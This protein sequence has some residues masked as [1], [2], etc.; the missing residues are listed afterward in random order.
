MLTQLSPTADLIPL[1]Q[2]KS[3]VMDI[4]VSDSDLVAYDYSSGYTASMVIK[5]K[6]SDVVLDTLN[7]VGGRIV[8]LDGADDINVQLAW[9]SAESS[10]I[11]INS[12]RP[13]GLVFLIGD[14]RII[15]NSSESEQVIRIE[16]EFR[17][18]T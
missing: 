7:S 18:T 3:H 8:L 6:A 12:A 9:S 17:Q 4:S 5:E 15:N 13:T 16:F 1:I 11:L 2:G 10:A 14:L